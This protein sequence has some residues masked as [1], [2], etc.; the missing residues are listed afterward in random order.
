VKIEPRQA[1]AF[2]KKPDPRI[3]GVVIYGNDDGLV[4]ERAAQLARTVCEDLKD[5]F[6]VVDI[7]GDA[8]KGDPA[9]LADE[10]GAMSLMGGR[11]VI[12]VRPAG[13]ESAAALENLVSASA[14]DALIILEGGNLTPRSGL[15]AL[16]ETEPSLAALPCYA[17]SEGDLERLLE[18][19]ARAA[20][21]SVEEDAQGWIVE[22]LGGDRAQSRSEIDKLLLYMSS[23]ES[24]T[25]TLA[26]AAAVLGDTSAMD[27]DDVVGATFDGDL[28]L[29]D[30][31]LDR[32]FAE[33]GNAV[34]LVRALQRHADQLH[35]VSGHAKNGNLEAAM[36]K[37]RGLPRGGPVRRRFE[38][39]LRRWP[40]PRLS[41]A[42]SRILDAELEC[43]STGLPDQA[44]ARRLCLSLARAVR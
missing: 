12:R 42:L 10:F 32:V 1:D 36:F 4:A 41:Q 16:A 13:E 18:S 6:R 33:G 11:R 14:G 25:I 2:L 34:Q 28:V 31:A 22:R 17:D 5:P 37:A 43:K 15:R 9:R 27:V 3:R 40:L 44:I 38:N 29:L 20:G 7:A 23:S 35:L 8:L 39:H 21:F 19:S 26:D 24:K 30:R